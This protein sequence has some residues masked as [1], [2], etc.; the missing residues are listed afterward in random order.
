MDATFSS[1]ISI[2]VVVVAVAEVETG[3]RSLTRTWRSLPRA[4]DPRSRRRRRLLLITAVSKPSI[5]AWNWNCAQDQSAS[6]VL[7]TSAYSVR[8]VV[9][10]ATPASHWPR[11]SA[12]ATTASS[13]LPA[14]W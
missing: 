1:A 11:P 3:S 12:T 5:T 2:S 6:S 13:A 8:V 14:A 7:C 10:A 9:R 4:N